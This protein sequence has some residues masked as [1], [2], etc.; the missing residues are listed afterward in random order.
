[1]SDGILQPSMDVGMY[2]PDMWAVYAA[3]TDAF[4]AGGIV[5]IGVSKM[6]L[7]R[8]SEVH[9]GSP[10]PVEA[11]MWAWVG[12]KR[13]AFKLE[14]RIKRA[15]AARCTRGEWFRFN[16]TDPREKEIFTRTLNLMFAA[17]VG[18]MPKWFKVDGAQIAANIE[19]LAKKSLASAKKR[20]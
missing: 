3:L 8:V 7:V 17:E 18:S 13:R 1:M 2:D 14:G 10:F 15:F 6:P 11:A 4:E 16:Y 12:S 9:S 20:G 5:K 19:A